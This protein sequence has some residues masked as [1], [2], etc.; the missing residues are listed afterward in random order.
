MA[1]RKVKVTLSAQVQGYVSAM[2]KAAQ[3]TRETGSEAEK[4][5]QM[6]E[7]FNTLGTAMVGV[8]AAV[9]AAGAAA[10]K[11]G[12]DYNSMQQSSRAALE[13]LLGSAEAANAQMD[14]LD[15]F[16][17]NSPF[18]KQTFIEAQQ[19]LLGFGMEAE[20]VVPTLDA[21]QNAV[22][23]TGGSNQDI[24]ELVRIIAQLEGG[25]KISAETFNQFGTRGVDAAGII[26]EAMGKTG[27]Q[28]REEVTA[29]TLD[30]DKA[31]QALTDGMQERFGGAADN[32]KD[33][34]DG[35]VDRVK[36]AWR[37]F[38]A[39]LAKPLVDPEGG[40][41]LVDFLNGLADAMRGFE[42]LPDPV[43]EAALS[44]TGLVG[45]VSLVGGTA[46]LAAPKVAKFKETL[47]GLDMTAGSAAGAIG[48]VSLVLATIPAA[49][50]LVDWLDGIRE[51]TVASD[52]LESQFRR[53]GV[54][55]SDLERGLTGGSG[56]RGLG[57]D[58]ELAA[59]NLRTLNTGIGRIK[60][61]F[62]NSTL[63]TIMSAPFL[64]LGREAG[65]AQKQIEE[66]DAAM[67]GMV[68]SGDTQAAADAYEYFAEKAAEA[69][70]STERIAEALPE[71]TQA[72]KEAGPATQTSAERAAEAASAYTEQADAARAATDELFR[73]IDALMESN[74]VAQDA[75]GANAKYQE[76]LAEVAD[77]VAN[78]QAGVEGYSASLDANTVEGSKNREMLAGMA[79]DSQDAALKIMEQEASTLGA[80]AATEN[81]KGRLEEGRQALYNTIVELTGNAEAAQALTDKLYAMPTQ[82]E[83][84]IILDTLQAMHDL[85]TY[86]GRLNSIPSVVTTELRQFQSLVYKDPASLYE[87]EGA[88]GF[89]EEY[90]RGGIEEYARGG[91]SPGIYRGGAPIH[92]FAEPET[93]WEAYI[94]GKPSERDRNRQIWVDAGERL[95]MG[96]LI[97]ALAGGGSGGKQIHVGGVS[98]NAEKPRDQMRELEDT[99]SRLI[100][101]G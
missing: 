97:E 51:V 30:A 100:R 37:D 79:A 39:E 65:Q 3:A 74:S 33:T 11:T 93:I 27:Q 8:G 63:G 83:I 76:T 25:V 90:A 2:E 56:F 46:V 89:I 82:Q 67:A 16:A 50:A 10:L 17:R 4:L 98:I 5:A 72:V 101:E 55:S 28:I 38:S 22:A 57:I 43:K 14:K 36:A 54:A 77:Y 40:G 26:G 87:T 66:L 95:G 15:D 84:D 92:K 71:Y 49:K 86:I 96:D 1:E 73:L 23:A 81:Y 88:D 6:R 78:A 21:I 68:S 45:A 53:M 41:A 52:D 70:W 59:N 12:I 20:R 69:G 91:F 31:I 24:A 64:G 94:S 19:Q 9:A 29:G 18:A 58:A 32:V 7:A 75:E 61:E 85:D 13:T 99:L 35:A 80:A 44:M 60:A 42:S 47:A 62:D 48:K 34:F